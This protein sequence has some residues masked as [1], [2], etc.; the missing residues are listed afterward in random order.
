MFYSIIIL[1]FYSNKSE[2]RLG[3]PT[4]DHLVCSKLL[5]YSSV[6]CKES[7]CFVLHEANLG[8]AIER[9]RRQFGGEQYREC[10]CMQVSDAAR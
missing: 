6:M 7:L 10:I 9:V 5:P 1:G 8:R 4:F 2:I 3:R